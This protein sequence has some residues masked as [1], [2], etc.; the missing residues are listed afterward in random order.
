MAEGLK[1]ASDVLATSLNGSSHLI[2]TGMHPVHKTWTP[3]LHAEAQPKQSAA[4]CTKPL[5]PPKPPLG[6]ALG[7]ALLLL[8]KSAPARPP[9]RG[10]DV[11]PTVLRC[12]GHWALAFGILLVGSQLLG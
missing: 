7:S 5:L 11:P 9:P 10:W 12:P 4:N 3:K 8:Y 6:S 2:F 1:K